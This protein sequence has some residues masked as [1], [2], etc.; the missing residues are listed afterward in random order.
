[1]TKFFMK[2]YLLTV[3]TIITLTGCGADSEGGGSEGDSSGNSDDGNAKTICNRGIVCFFEN[4][5]NFEKQADGTILHKDTGLIWQFNY[6]SSSDKI[7]PL[8]YNAAVAYCDS[9]SIHGYNDWRLP[10]SYEMFTLYDFSQIPPAFMP[11]LDMTQ[12]EF[13]TSTRTVSDKGTLIWIINYHRE[14]ILSSI[15]TPSGLLRCVRNDNLDF[16]SDFYNA[17]NDANRYSSADGVVTDSLTGLQWQGSDATGDADGTPNQLTNLD[18]GEAFTVCDNLVL[19]GESDW[20]VPTAL[21]FLS[22]LDFNRVNNAVNPIF[23]MTSMIEY[24][25]STQFST[26]ESIKVQDYYGDMKKASKSESNYLRCV[27]P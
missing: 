25:T 22:I 26:T 24:W 11:I 6:D 1:M 23:S 8:M 3:L 2:K 12:D 27:R 4:N 19:G 17:L 21:E 13:M 20:R 9:L 7:L 18:N 10:S 16:T 5:Q 15:A 14:G